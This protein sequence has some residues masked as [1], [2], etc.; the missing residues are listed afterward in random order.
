VGLVYSFKPWWW[1]LVF[2]EALAGS[3]GAIDWFT[4]EAAAVGLDF[5][6]FNG[7]S[8]EH[9]YPEVVSPGAAFL[10]YDNDGDLDIYL[11]QGRMLG[12]W[13]LPTDAMFPPS[14]EASLRDRL[15]RNDLTTAIGQNSSCR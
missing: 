14:G 3:A 5:V 2:A 10:D 7:M 4:D 11:V 12:S 13:K 1:I 15:Y 6:H 9:F 8:G